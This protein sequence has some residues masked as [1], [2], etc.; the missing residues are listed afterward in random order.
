MSGSLSGDIEHVRIGEAVS[1]SIGRPDQEQEVFTGPDVLP[2][3][4]PGLKLPNLAHLV[5]NRL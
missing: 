5:G 1:I 2:A 3:Q 4:P